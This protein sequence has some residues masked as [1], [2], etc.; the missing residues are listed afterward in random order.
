MD[1]E[2]RR[3]KF[4]SSLWGH[5]ERTRPKE[6]RLSLRRARREDAET[7]K[8]FARERSSRKRYL[9]DVREKKNVFWGEFDIF[10]LFEPGGF[11]RNNNTRER[12]RE[13]E[14]SGENAPINTSL[15]HGNWNEEDT[16]A[17]RDKKKVNASM[18]GLGESTTCVC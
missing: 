7:A 1:R 13:R 18:C 17:R 2:S 15:S 14:R 16:D 10:C 6:K 8:R 9:L 4:P 5:R 3:F 11:A 12:E